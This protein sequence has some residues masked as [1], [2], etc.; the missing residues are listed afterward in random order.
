MEQTEHSLRV[1][2]DRTGDAAYIY[3]TDIGLGRVTETVPMDPLAVDGMINLDFDQ[4]NRL[5]GIEVLEASRRLPPELL[6][7][8]D[9]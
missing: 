1:T 5:V 6:L 8:Q 7:S 9:A 4:E 2:Y 3:L